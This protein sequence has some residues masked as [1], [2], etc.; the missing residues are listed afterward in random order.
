MR[1]NPKTWRIGFRSASS[2][3][4]SQ[5]RS[6]IQG[7]TMGIYSSLV[8]IVGKDR[9]SNSAAELYLYSRDSGAQP[10][11]R[12][13]YV[14]LPKTA[15]EIR[16]IVLLANRRNIPITPLGGGLS[17]SGLVVPGR[18]GIVLDM[19][20]MDRILG[21]DE[22]NRYALIEAGVSQGALKSYLQ[23]HHPRLQHSTPEAPPT[24][25]V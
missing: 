21:V 16:D 6:L 18:G 2:R 17:L 5:R 22:K 11:G 4:W 1:L 14:V 7:D 19:K 23:K 12:A 15:E 3:N 20:R 8:E 13:D 24:A 25:T 10:P 9:V